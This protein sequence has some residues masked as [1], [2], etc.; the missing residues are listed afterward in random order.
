MKQANSKSKDAA[1]A[2]LN[3]N[4][5]LRATQIKFQNEGT[6][7]EVM[8]QELIDKLELTDQ[9]RREFIRIRF[10]DRP[11]PTQ[12]QVDQRKRDIEERL[13]AAGPKRA[14]ANHEGLMSVLT[15]EQKAKWQEMIGEPFAFPQPRIAGGFPPV[16]RK[17]EPEKKDP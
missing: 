13:K 2:L 12:E 10:G 17:S 3:E 15:P 6:S 9:Q 4:Q 1:L 8:S 14:T 16:P 7:P 11:V 5:R